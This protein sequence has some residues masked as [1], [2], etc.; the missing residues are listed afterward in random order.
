MM[1]RISLAACCVCLL[2]SSLAVAQQAPPA[3][4]ELVVDQTFDSD[5]LDSKWHINTGNWAVKD[6][7]LKVSEVA[8]DKHAA[9]ARFPVETNNAVYQLRFRLLGDA[10]AFHFGFDPAPG[11]LDKKGHLFSVIVTP[12]AWKIMKH[13]DKKNPKQ[14]PNEVLANE[15]MSFEK[16]R[17]YTL[18][19]TTW[20][21]YVTATIDGDG[22][23]K[24]SH[25]T[26]GVKKPTLVFRC[27][28]DGVEVDDIKVWRQ[29][30]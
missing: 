8:S 25:P 14:D 9:A 6:G 12:S 28:G 22:T 13:V 7:V 3:N 1:I 23:L 29:V 19:L 15:S 30:K 16:D 11:E 10:K 21:T 4:S 24:A 18:R 5:S 17:W 20:E 27:Q 2:S 26:F